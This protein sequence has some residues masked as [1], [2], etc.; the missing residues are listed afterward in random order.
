MPRQGV[1]EEFTNGQRHVCCLE[2][3]PKTVPPPVSLQNCESLPGYKCI[4]G[5]VRILI[6][7]WIL[8]IMLTS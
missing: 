3:K 5:L 4:P 1:C 6:L 7:P 8:K 2:T